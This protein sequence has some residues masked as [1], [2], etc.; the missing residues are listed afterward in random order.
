M[1]PLT[2]YVDGTYSS[3]TGIGGFAVI[4]IN[5][6]GRIEYG[7]VLRVGAFGAGCLAMEL[8]A[9]ITAIRHAPSH[10]AVA[11]YSDCLTIVDVAA[12]GHIKSRGGLKEE[13]DTLLSLVK[14][15]KNVSIVWVRGDDVDKL[16][17]FA[18]RAA[19]EAAERFTYHVNGLAGNGTL[20]AVG[21]RRTHGARCINCTTLPSH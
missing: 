21:R 12:R 15:K 3:R 11:I 18:D 2:Y 16:N 5:E 9:A 4:P 14:E 13:W 6:N 20:R 8:Q 1:K 17:K 10:R 19:R 7:K